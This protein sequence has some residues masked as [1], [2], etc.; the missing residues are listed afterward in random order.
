M[1]DVLSVTSHINCIVAACL[2]N[3]VYLM[4]CAFNQVMMMSHFSNDVANDPESIQKSKIK[5]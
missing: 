4:A 3:I 1:K 5:S 2:I